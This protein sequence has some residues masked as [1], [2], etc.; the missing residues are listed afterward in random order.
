MS[1]P[2][3]SPSMNGILVVR[4]IEFAVGILS[5]FFSHT[6]ILRR[7][8]EVFLDESPNSEVKLSEQRVIDL[9]RRRRAIECV[10]VESRSVGV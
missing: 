2:M 9:A 1:T 3:P 6:A 4:D 5:D 10:E 8:S 7:F